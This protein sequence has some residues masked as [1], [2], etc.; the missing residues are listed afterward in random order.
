MH[1]KRWFIRFDD[2]QGYPDGMTVD[3]QDGLWVAHWG[4]SRVSRFH[5]DGRLDCSIALPVS[6]VTSCVFGGSSLDR[7]FVTSASIGLSAEQLVREPLAGGL[8]EVDPQ[9]KSGLPAAQFAG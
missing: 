4:G 6:Q 7:M 9:G 5:S 3:A 8:F 2:T 1:D